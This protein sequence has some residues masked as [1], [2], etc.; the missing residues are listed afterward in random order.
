M[1]FCQQ[2]TKHIKHH[3]VIA[4]SPFTLKMTNCIDQTRQE[5]AHGILAL[6]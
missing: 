4:K 6:C 1:L 3:L 5:K 2:R